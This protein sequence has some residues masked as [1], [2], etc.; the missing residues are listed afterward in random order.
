VSQYDGARSRALRLQAG[1]SVEELATAAG[2]SPSTVRS[3]ESGSQP[4]PRV[5][6]ALA[7]ALGVP[8]DELAP[9]GP[10]LTLRDVRR[11]LGLTQAEMGARIGVVRQRISQVERG[12]TGVRQPQS[13]ARA[14]RLTP[15]QWS[16]AHTAARTLVRK[17]VAAQTRQ[18]RTTQRGDST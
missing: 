6:T 4:G 9:P 5:A 2:V 15:S 17:K 1:V 3:A 8:L 18:R 16:R 7:R 12:V 14:Y 11:R 13:W 10:A